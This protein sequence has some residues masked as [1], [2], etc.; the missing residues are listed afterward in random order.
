MIQKILIANRGEIA[1][2]IM[3]SCKEMGIRTVAV[4]SEADRT[5]KHVMYADEACLIGPAA[6]HESYLTIDN[7][8]KAAKLHHADAIHPGYGFLSEN[9]E[10]ARRC[11]KE[12]IIFI[13][14]AAETM[15]AMGDKISARKRMIAA[16][17]PVVPGTEQ[18]LQSGEEAVRICKEIGFP[19]M[20]K[21]SMGGGG[22]GMRLIHSEDEVLEAYNT[23]RSE[24]MSSFGDD[25]VYLEKFVE[26][27]HHIE[28]QILGDNHGNVI[29]LFDRECSVQRRHQKIVEESPSPFLTPELRKEMGEKAVA[30]A[31]AV[32]YSGAGTIEF[33]VDKHR[34]FYFL[35]MN[36]RLQ[37]EHPITEEVC[38]V[39][40]VMEQ[41]RV[42]NDEVL[43]LKQEDLLQRGHAIE[44]R[45]CAED[46]ENNFL[47]SPGI[48]KQLTEPNGIGVR[49]DSYVYEGYEIPI[50]YDPMIGKL[51]VW[52]TT[53]QYAI[54]R[55]RR[56]LYEYK[57]TGLKTNLSYLKR[58]MHTPD[59][60]RGEYNTLFIEKN[61]RMLQRNNSNN[62]EIENLAMIAAY[63]DYLMNLEEN[64]PAQLTDARPISRWREFG[65]QKGVLRI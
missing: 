2:R 64:T 11:K 13:G 62:E 40:L 28:F 48:I 26:E 27:P 18:P 56:V 3:R 24:S 57:I 29:H 22:K 32:N 55:M 53:R 49:I 30:A 5:S 34:N 25:T 16:G 59:F 31:K 51:I 21:A 19:V 8:I 46:T 14:P 45:I 50:Y 54:E 20:L 60:V 39:D 47:P 4:F 42:A 38:G 65:L 44:C 12:G 58:I 35:E 52:A 17:V 43:H 7:I 15:E 6:S 37:V 23:A 1:V 61:A 36:T 10:F 41:I 63:I 9:A 33:L